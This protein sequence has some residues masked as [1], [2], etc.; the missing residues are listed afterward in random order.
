MK[1]EILNCPRHGILIYK[2]LDPR[3]FKRRSGSA[4]DCQESTSFI[5]L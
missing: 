4:T 3:R 2:I 5:C 1:R